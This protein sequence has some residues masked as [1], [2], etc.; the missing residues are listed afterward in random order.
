MDT[1]NDYSHPQW[2]NAGRVHEWKNYISDEVKALW[3]TFT[4]AQRQ[5]LSRQAEDI[6]DQEDW[7]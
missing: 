1:P 6:A 2:D 4:D 3:F 5:A 7:D